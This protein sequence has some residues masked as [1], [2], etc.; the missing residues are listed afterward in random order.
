M[1]FTFKHIKIEWLYGFFIWLYLVKG[2]EIKT[3]ELLRNGI[4]SIKSTIF[5]GP[6]FFYLKTVS[7]S[8]LEFA[9]NK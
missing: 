6:W 8:K 5:T 4:L 9:E 7:D 2:Y 3:Q 1:T